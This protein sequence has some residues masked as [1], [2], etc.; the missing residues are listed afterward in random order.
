MNILM[1]FI[2]FRFFFYRIFYIFQLYV[3]GEIIMEKVLFVL[4]FVSNVKGVYSMFEQVIIVVFYVY[5]QVCEC[6]MIGGVVNIWV[7]YEVV[8]K[9]KLVDVLNFVNRLFVLGVFVLVVY[10][11]GI[12]I[13]LVIFS[14]FVKYS[15][16]QDKYFVFY[17]VCLLDDEMDMK[18][19]LDEKFF[20]VVD[21]GVEDSFV[22]VNSFEIDFVD[23]NLI[24]ESFESSIYFEIVKKLDLFEEVGEVKFVGDGIVDKGKFNVMIVVFVS[25]VG[26]DLDDELSVLFDV[27]WSVGKRSFL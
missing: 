27:G 6:G 20:F 16:V 10:I 24:F 5:E 21:N 25:F 8:V 14:W 26:E 22:Y 23:C 18:S 3:L 11:V 13:V 4:G 17:K 19:V 2:N 7:K 12:F 9:F 15:E 1:C